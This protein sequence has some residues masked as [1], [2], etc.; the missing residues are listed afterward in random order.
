MI[1]RLIKNVFVM[2][3]VIA[4]CLASNGA[5]P[6]G[7][8]NG[9]NGLKDS[10]LKNK[11]HNIINTGNSNNYSGLFKNCFI[12]TDVRDNGTWWDMY[13]NI[14]RATI[15]NNKI[16]WTGMNREHSFPKSWWGGVDNDAYTDINHLY[17]SD[18]PAN[19]AKLNY[20]LGE[21]N[22]AYIDYDNGLILVGSPVQGQGGGAKYVFEPADEY[23]GDF[24]RTYFYM[25]TC[26][27]HLTWKYT[28][29]AANNAYPTLQ[30]WAI[31]LLLKWHRAD[32][33]SKKEINRN[34]EVYRIQRNRNPFIDYPELAEFIWGDKKGQAFTSGEL[35][36]I[37]VGSLSSPINNEVVDFGDVVVGHSK[38]VTLPIRGKLTQ[39]LSL[40]TYGKDFADFSIPVTSVSWKDVNDKG[41]NLV[42]TYKPTAVAADNASLLLYDGGLQGLTSYTITLKG[43]AHDMPTFDRP[44]AIEAT[45][46]TES[47][48]R[49]NWNVPSMPETIDYYVVTISEYV[50]GEVV[51]KEYVTEDNLN[52]FD[53]S[54]AVSGADY[55]YFVQSVRFDVRSPESNVISVKLGG[56][57]W[58]ST[59]PFAVARIQN[60][61]QFRC[62]GTHTNVCIYDMTG[63]IVSSIP[64]VSNGDCVL[65]PFGAYM[66]VTDQSPAPV[67]VLV[68][69]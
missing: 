29:M 64:E 25:V 53:F 9:I 31:D 59:Q 57:E 41:Y 54:E 46:V 40:N 42:I 15:V 22:R 66:V 32:P 60:G 19:S 11:L 18:G 49:V 26:Y 24:A 21:V 52:Y 17:P 23:K 58:L 39:N 68:G 13:S 12:H 67:K 28:Y 14:K 45:E 2:V 48:F 47:G 35:P 10:A 20:P 69:Y 43:Q 56:V 55:T 5:V 50:N 37:G 30:K 62:E 51:R 8:Y 36:P 34:D 4:G 7:Y 38:S 3:A 27:Q 16:S 33:V 44:V 1:T 63:R 65:L 61:I 6:A